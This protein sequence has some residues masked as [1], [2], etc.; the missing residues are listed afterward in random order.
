MPEFLRILVDA[1]GFIPHG[2]CYLW[3][4]ELVWLHVVSDSLTAIAYYSISFM[5]V[6]FVHKRRDVPFDWIFLMFGSFIVA[7]GTTHLFEVWTL[8]HPTYWLSGLIK[9][10]TA[11]VLLGTAV[12]LVPLIPKALIL[13]SPAQLQVTNLA[14]RNE[15]TQRQEA[16]ELLDD[17]LTLTK[18]EVGK[19]E[20]ELKPFDLA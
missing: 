8:W 16:E 17:I 18:A 4:A 1:S 3:K 6:Y 11:L 12:L 15:I 20:V 5:L 9:A 10:I 2:H 13:P 7:C 19:L 14:L